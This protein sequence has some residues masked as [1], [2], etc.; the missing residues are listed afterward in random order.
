M[1][2]LALELDAVPVFKIGSIDKKKEVN[3]PSIALLSD[4]SPKRT[5]SGHVC[6]TWDTMPHNRN[7]SADPINFPFLLLN[8]TVH[9]FMKRLGP[10]G[11]HIMAHYALNLTSEVK[12][13]NEN[14]SL[15]ENAMNY[16]DNAIYSDAPDLIGAIGCNGVV[17]R[18]G[19][20]AGWMISLLRGRPSIL[21]DPVS[22]SCFKA[23]S[24]FAGLLNPLYP[25]AAEDNILS[26]VNKFCGNHN[27]TRDLLANLL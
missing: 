14:I 3:I 7:I 6:N 16:F 24:Y 10:A 20:D 18:I 27:I 9:K 21:Y 5:E 22:K 8:P 1:T 12:Q 4:K 13:T 17:Y 15:E 19:D 2:S 23:K 11:Y 25:G 26:R